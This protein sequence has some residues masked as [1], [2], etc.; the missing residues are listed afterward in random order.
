MKLEENKEM[1]IESNIVSPRDQLNVNSPL[2]N[3]TLNKS[4]ELTNVL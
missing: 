1:F 3:Q 2:K 4:A